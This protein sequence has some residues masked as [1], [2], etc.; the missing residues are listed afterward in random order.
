[1]PKYTITF[2]ASPTDAKALLDLAVKAL[3]STE[4]SELH[5]T[6]DGAGAEPLKR[7]LTPHHRFAQR[8]G[9]SGPQ[10]VFELLQS[11]NGKMKR[12]VIRKN[13]VTK[14]YAP[15]SVG[16]FTSKLKRAGLVEYNS[17]N[18]Y[19][20]TKGQAHIWPTKATKD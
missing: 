5:F 1:M 7:T 15:A 10:M 19:L 12:E 14:G 17:P 13:L 2:T 18:Y 11:A 9:I 8:T 16:P 3:T 6:T 20:T 4:L